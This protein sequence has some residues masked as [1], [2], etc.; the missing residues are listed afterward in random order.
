MLVQGKRRA[1]GIPSLL[2]TGDAFIFTSIAL[3]VAAVVAGLNV[4]LGLP[5]GISALTG[6]ILFIGLAG[7]QAWR[8]G[9][10][11][12][13]RLADDLRRL[14]EALDFPRAVP[15]VSDAP[16]VPAFAQTSNAVHVSPPVAP[17]SAWV[18][19]DTDFN[20]DPRAAGTM[21]PAAEPERPQFEAY[22][23]VPPV[24]PGQ[25]F[26]DYWPTASE[27]HPEVWP[28]TAP[29]AEQAPV[30][31][32]SQAVRDDDVELLQRR[33]KDML[34]QV[35]AA[36]QARELAA[37]QQSVVETAPADAISASVD[38]LQ[39]AVHSMRERADVAAAL[40]APTTGH[41]APAG[42]LQPETVREAIASGR[43][44]VFLEPILGLGD[45]STQHYEVSIKLRGWAMDDLGDGTD[46]VLTGRGILP[47][48]DAV[49]IERSAIVAEK[50]RS[51][52]KGGAVFSRASGEA[53][54]EPDFTRNMQMDFVARPMTARRLILT[55]SQADIRSFRAAEQRAIS[56][57][58][59]LG[60]RFAIGG[61]TDLDMNFAAMAKAG[62]A[63][64]KIDA[65]VVVDGLAHPG[66]HVPASDVCRFLADQGFGLIVDGIENEEMLARLFGFGVLMGQGAL[67][68]GPRPVKA[69]VVTSRGQ[70]A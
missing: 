25:S 37:A 23:G 57:L 8:R 14:N 26:S 24:P 27:V 13:S 17:V 54:L 60:F 12:R 5:F 4:Q 51:R 15:A 40:D 36:E 65:A 70:A 18:A 67:F 61:L 19:D 29:A 32:A 46:G 28:Q 59:A 48:F 66:G 39:A 22:P 44:D 11:E 68:G 42:D 6:L 21:A 63:F 64:V 38:A 56:A 58:S 41:P 52:G 69:D 9:E 50:L 1:L 20:I 30:V 31:S 47:L 55:F 53:L 45:Q 62:F 33:I 34:Y 3:V 43:V 16:A 10:A 2:G 7:L 35:N 49:R